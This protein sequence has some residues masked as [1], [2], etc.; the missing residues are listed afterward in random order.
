M[1]D[2]DEGVWRRRERSLMGGVILWTLL[3]SGSMVFFPGALI[4]LLKSNAPH[5]I[6]G[7]TLMTIGYFSAVVNVFY[8]ITSRYVNEE[9]ALS[10][11]E[12]DE[13]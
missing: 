13:I 3:I 7:L 10:L 9:N 11:E 1:G 2:I 5:E 12:V 6:A 8:E 4:S